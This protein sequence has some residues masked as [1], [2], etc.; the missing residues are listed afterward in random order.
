MGKYSLIEHRMVILDDTIEG[1]NLLT[2]N[3]S[4]LSTFLFLFILKTTKKSVNIDFRL[5]KTVKI[6]AYTNFEFSIH[7]LLY[8]LL[9]NR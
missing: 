4:C 9:I 1:Q 2:G 7:I 6:T 5:C 3:L 8:H